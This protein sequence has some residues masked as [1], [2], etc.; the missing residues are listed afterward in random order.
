METITVSKAALIETLAHNR[1]VHRN[2]FLQAQVVYREKMIEE[3][4]RALD[5]ARKGGTIQRAFRLPVPEDHTDDFDTALKM[6]EWH[7]GDQIE[8]SDREFSQY[9][10]NKWGWRAAF[11]SNTEAYLVTEG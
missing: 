11:H 2:T 3:L 1:G 5:E 7:Q 9:V 4:D 6:L 10:E 8:L